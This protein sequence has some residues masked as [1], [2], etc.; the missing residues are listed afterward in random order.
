MQLI[1]DKQET[2]RALDH[3][4]SF[5]SCPLFRCWPFRVDKFWDRLFVTFHGYE[6]ILFYRRRTFNDVYARL[7]CTYW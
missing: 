7:T 4:D 2:I 3:G 5:Q 1:A 6:V